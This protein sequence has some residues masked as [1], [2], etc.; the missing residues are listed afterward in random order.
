MLRGDL[1]ARPHDLARVRRAVA[2]RPCWSPRASAV[3]AWPCSFPT[4]R[5]ARRVPRPRRPESSRSASVRGP[6]TARSTT[7]CET[8]SGLVA[9]RRR[10]PARSPIDPTRRRSPRDDALGAVSSWVPGAARAQD[11]APIHPLTLG[12]DDLFL[13]NSTSG[14]TGL[15]KCVMH[16]PDPLVAT[17]TA[18]RRAGDLTRRRVPQRAPGAVRLRVVDRALHAALSARRA[19]CSNASTPKRCSRASSAIV[20][21]CSRCVSTQFV[22]MLNSPAIERH[23]LSSLRVHVHRRRDG[24]LRAAPASSRSAP[25]QPSSSSTGRTRPARSP[26]DAPDDREQR[27]QHRRP[28]HPRDEVRLF[29]DDG[30]DVTTAGRPGHP[31]CQGP[32]T[33]LG[34]LD[35]DGGQRASCSPP[36]AGCAWATSARSTPTAT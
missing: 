32:A 17:S 35:D 25:A 2:L 5:R 16:T 6:A 23:D 26:H 3:H 8:R 18:R 21:P 4:A 31:A 19:S 14:T 15:P 27:L 34:Y 33:C 24:P 1:G 10:P 13:L 22:M 9:D 11:T 29:D 20:S 28:R 12:P 36:T 7:S 30:A